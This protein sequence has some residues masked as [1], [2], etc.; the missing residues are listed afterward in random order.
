M[1]YELGGGTHGM[2]KGLWGTQDRND[3]ETLMYSITLPT[4]VAKA[5]NLE[6]PN[7]DCFEELQTIFLPCVIQF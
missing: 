5:V 1:E 4:L 6:F 7:C 2:T 3:G